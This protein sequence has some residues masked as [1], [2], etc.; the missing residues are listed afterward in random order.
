MTR[1]PPL[2]PASSTG[3]GYRSVS[4]V[5]QLLQL[6]RC[7]PFVIHRVPATDDG[8]DRVEEPPCARGHRSPARPGPALRPVP[9]PLRGAAG[10]A[11][12]GDVAGEGQVE[13]GRGHPPGLADGCTPPG[14]ATCSKCPTRSN[15]TRS[16]TSTSPP[17]GSRLRRNRGRRGRHRSPARYGR[18]R[19]AGSHVGMVVSD[20]HERYCGSLP[21][22]RVLRR[23]VLRVEVVGDRLG[24]DANSREKCSMPSRNDRNVS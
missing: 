22:D 10:S 3:T 7:L 16:A 20:P 14:M 12:C 9:R 19:P 13:V 4:R 8:R 5:G 6:D 15:D 24:A 21:F 2:L 17:T 1:N 18:C 23:Q 11:V